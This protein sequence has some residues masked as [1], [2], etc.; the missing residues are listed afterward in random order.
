MAVPDLTSAPPA[1]KKAVLFFWASWHS[2]SA[3]R[4]A[5]DRV[6]N[7]LEASTRQSGDG[8]VDFY[9]VE[10]EAVPDLSLKVRGHMYLV[11]VGHGSGAFHA[12]LLFASSYL[13]NHSLL[14]TRHQTVRR[15]SRPYLHSAGRVWQYS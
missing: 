2:D 3:P 14:F 13:T 10:A 15:H 5:I 7:T 8:G 4:G 6:F 12:Y 11:L 9:R 1:G